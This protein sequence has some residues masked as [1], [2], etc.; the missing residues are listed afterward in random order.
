[1]AE[2]YYIGHY[3]QL[4]PLTREQ[5][6]DLID[7]GVVLRETYVWRTGMPQWATAGSIVELSASF[8]A[9]EPFSAPPPPPMAMPTLA[10]QQGPPQPF[11]QGFR[12]PGHMVAN[13]PREFLTVPSDRSRVAA[14]VLNILIPFGIGRM[15][16]G[17]VAIGV[18]QLV[19]APCGIGFIWSI[20]DGIAILCGATKYD[21][22]GRHLRD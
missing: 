19:L 18:L 9:A 12:D 10:T 15:Y 4:G 13:Y 7:G 22:L 6:D 5:L 3:G 8:R 2:W 14:G 20:V 16:L 1:M 11:S 21:G 17:Y